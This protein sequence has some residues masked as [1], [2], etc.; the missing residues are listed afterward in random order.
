LKR[1]RKDKN[2]S[3]K[4]VEQ[5]KIDE[6]KADMSRFFEHPKLHV[7]SKAG[8]KLE[9]VR[10]RRGKKFELPIRIDKVSEISQNA[11]NLNI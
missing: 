6:A 8:N 5:Q 11:K 9:A 10:K 2:E 3:K 7:A 4:K 1:E